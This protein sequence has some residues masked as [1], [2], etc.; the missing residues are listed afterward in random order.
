MDSLFCAQAYAVWDA[1][2]L[3]VARNSQSNADRQKESTG[4]CV[5]LHHL[6][7]QPFL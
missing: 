4:N 3:N 5:M 6:I 2:P 1:A 7:I